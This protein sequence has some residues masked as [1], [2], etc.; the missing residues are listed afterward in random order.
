ML[1]QRFFY[2]TKGGG[3]DERGKIRRPK[4]EATKLYPEEAPEKRDFWFRMGFSS[5]SA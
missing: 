3:E 2:K 1:P 4:H 5:E